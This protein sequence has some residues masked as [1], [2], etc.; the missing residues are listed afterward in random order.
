MRASGVLMHITS[1]PSNYGVGCLCDVDKFIKFLVRS[2]QQYWQILPVN[3]TDYYNNPYQSTSAFA[4]NTLL[5]DVEQLCNMGLL[6]F[7]TINQ[8]RNCKGI[9]YQY[10][11]EVKDIL[12]TIAYN[13]FVKNNPSIEYLDFVEDN[14]YWLNDYAL[15]SALKEHF[16]N[17]SWLL[18]SDKD[19]VNRVPISI[20]QYNDK[21]YDRVEYHKFC[22]YI[23]FVQWKV[24]RKQLQDNNIKLIGDTPMYV[25]YDSADVWVNRELFCLNN[26]QPS[27]VSAIPRDFEGN[28]YVMG[29]PVYNWKAMKK[30]NYS[31]WNRRIAHYSNMYDMLRIDNAQCFDRYYTVRYGATLAKLCMWHSGKAGALLGKIVSNYPQ[32]P[33]ISGENSRPTDNYIRIRDS[34]G[35]IKQKTLQWSLLGDSYNAMPQQYDEMCVAYLSAQEGCNWWW[36]KVLDKYRKQYALTQQDINWQ[37]MGLLMSS[38]AG[39][40]MVSMQDI[41]GDN[42]L[43]STVSWQYMATNGDFS[44]EN[45]NRLAQLTESY[46]R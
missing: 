33:I 3:P 23:F 39:T 37:L 18:W 43:P 9:D 13:N 8:Y 41:A 11:T 10:A 6:D 14:A 27:Q 16:N 5:I 36:D 17:S 26:N 38:N 35:I 19:I 1:L 46:Q 29:Q 20:A 4:G 25:C 34:Y 32:L 2:K 45:A 31:W 22:Q 21:L 44:N 24:F 42:S 30:D 28:S 15:Y 7:A 12:L 40:T